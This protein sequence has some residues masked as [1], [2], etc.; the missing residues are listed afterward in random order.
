VLSVD[1]LF[2]LCPCSALQ[3]PCRNIIGVLFDP[4]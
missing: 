2:V 1:F 4:I 3:A